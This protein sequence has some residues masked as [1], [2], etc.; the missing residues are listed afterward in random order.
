VVPIALSLS[1]VSVRRT[2]STPSVIFH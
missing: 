2:Q 1:I